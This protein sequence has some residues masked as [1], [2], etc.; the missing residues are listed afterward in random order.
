MNKSESKY[1]NTAKLMNTALV[2][3]LNKKDYEFITIKEICAKAGVSRSTFYLHYD[4]VDDLL[5]ECIENQNKDFLAYFSQNVENFVA[6][7][8]TCPM[9]ELVFITPQYLTPYLQYIKEN[10]KIHLASVKHPYIMNAGRKSESLY[11]YVFRPIFRRFGVD[12]SADKYIM[13]YYI[14]GVVS[15]INEWIKGGCVDSIEYIE[16][17][18][19]SCIRPYAK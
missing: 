10:S 16:D 3:L 5:E 13:A 4:T 15:I 6:K 1:L 19:I 18:I 7:I 11:K 8:D 9:D 17:I 12:E 2:E 14:N